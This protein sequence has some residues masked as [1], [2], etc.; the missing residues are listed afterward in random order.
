MKLTSGNYPCPQILFYTVSDGFENQS[1]NMAK[2]TDGKPRAKFLESVIEERP[3]IIVKQLH[4][5]V[6]SRGQFY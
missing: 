1:E 4:M 6:N 2:V 5:H 3:D